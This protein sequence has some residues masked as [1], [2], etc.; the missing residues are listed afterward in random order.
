MADDVAVLRK[1]L[2][3]VE[4]DAADLPWANDAKRGRR[5]TVATHVWWENDVPVVDLHDLGA[6]GARSAVDAV[7][8]NPAEAG[9]V[10]FVHGRGKHSRGPQVLHKVVQ[11]ELARACG[12]EAGWSF[13]TL[14]PGRT[15]WISDRS[16]A[17]ASV[18]GGWGCGL[19]LVFAGLLVA[20][21]V[22]LG[23]AAGWW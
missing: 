3:D 5:W 12:A 15:V 18:T 11:A 4:R 13:R 23:H 10:V 22:A 7:L 2:R 21:A 20:A 6:A 9:A 19:R 16:R 8:A 14:G 17:P 1:R